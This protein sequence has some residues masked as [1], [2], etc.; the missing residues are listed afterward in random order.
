[1]AVVQSD[2][3]TSPGSAY[4]EWE[5]K[6]GDD[7]KK[8]GP[9]CSVCNRDD[10]EVKH[11]KAGGGAAYVHVICKSCGHVRFFDLPRFSVFL[12]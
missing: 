11:P 6:A 10:Y 1:M 3:K 4:A 5:Q 2:Y 7:F 12:G 9:K 8:S